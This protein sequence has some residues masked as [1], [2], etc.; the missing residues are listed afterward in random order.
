MENEIAT[1][2]SWAAIA[3]IIAFVI[4]A[5]SIIITILAMAYRRVVETNTVHIVQSSGKT[6]SYGK[7]Q[8]AGNTYY[9][10]PS[11]IPVLGVK[12]IQLPMSVFDQTLD[13]YSAYDKDRLPFVIDVMAFFRISDSNMA[14]QR[15][16][17]FS[18]LLEQLRSILQGAVRSI[19]ASVDIHEILEGRSKFGELFTKEVD[20]QLKQWGVQTVKCIEIMDIRDAKDS[21]VIH[22]I[23]AKKKSEIEKDSRV[24]VA[25]NMQQ[26]Q[27]AEI[28][29]RREVDLKNVNAAQAVGMAKADQEK[30][31]GTQT[32]KSKQEVLAEAK[33]TAEKQMEVKRVE[34]VKTAEIDK[35]VAVVA[36]E[37]QKQTNIIDAEGKAQQ[38]AKIAE[39]A[40]KATKFKAEG[41]TAEGTAKAEAEKALQLAPVQAQITLAKEIGE[42]EGYQTYLV[43]LR[44]VEKEEKVGIE[45][46]KS[47]QKADIK[48]IANAGNPTDGV[49][50]VM[51]LFSAKGGTQLS[52]MVEAFA[53]TDAGKSVLA[54][55]TGS[56]K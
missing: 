17:S 35:D 6:V 53:Q 7:D 51:D 2:I 3:G 46:A 40:L 55:F 25:K 24:T 26:A 47:L 16:A 56:K 11:W 36:A 14:A 27:E 10:W 43:R 23:M 32:E 22:N 18:E 15:I 20:E 48:V 19:M 1:G 28:E 54:K 31:V 39:G 8:T 41:I 45:Q 42:N 52:A 34:Q 49:T 9:A 4:L 33:I 13:A 44:E 38:E 50:N 29:A 5:V 37:R 12:V 21:A 30:L